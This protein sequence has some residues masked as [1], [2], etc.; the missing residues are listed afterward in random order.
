M[1]IALPVILGI[2]QG[3]TEWLPISSSGHGMIVMMQF[4]NLNPDIALSI[5][6]YLH[7]GTLLAVIVKFRDEIKGIVKSIPEFR[8]D[9]LIQF[10]TVS[11][12]FTGVVGV[13]IYLLLRHVFLLEY[14]NSAMLFIG[15][16]LIL[17][18]F[19]LYVSKKRFDA[20]GT[21][22]IGINEMI[23]A[24]IA[25]GFAVLPGISR[26]GMTISSLLLLG[27][28]QDD[29]LR[30]SFIMSIP[31]VIGAVLLSLTDENLLNIGFLPLLIGIIIAFV[32]G[33]LT[34]GILMEISEKLRFDFF[35]IF[36]GI[37][38]L[39]FSLFNYL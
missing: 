5:A 25:Q 10:L 34:I 32:F 31:A 30:L 2:I 17:T 8:H 4:F 33:Y 18:G 23:I 21:D 38:T 7:T 13:P 6:M 35:C 11:T 12:L 28:K 14:A 39:A 15:F 9:K 16:C 29:S 20:K 26:S 22:D 3:I 19:I 24:G 36:F 27:V 37:L 1:D